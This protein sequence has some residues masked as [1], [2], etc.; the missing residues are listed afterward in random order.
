[1]KKRSLI[2]VVFVLL[3]LL[4]LSCE[5]ELPGSLNTNQSPRTRL[6]ISSEGI[7]NETLSKQH[8]YY[9]GEDPDGFISGYLIAVGKF[10]RS[11]TSVP[12]PD[13][14]T[15]VWTTRTDTVLSLPLLALRD[16]FTVLVR[17]VDNH[18]LP[19]AMPSGSLVKGFPN[20]YW[21]KDSNGFYS[22]GD[23][24]LTALAGAADPKGA[25]Q[26][27]P[28]VNTPPN[29]QFA[30]TPGDSPVT[31]EQP[32]TTFTAT[33]FS[34]V[35][36]DD[37]GNQTLKSYRL[38]LNDTTNPAN[39][40]ELPSSAFSK[41][42]KEADTVKVMLYVKRQDSDNAGP[43]VPAEIYI[44]VFGNLQYQGTINNLRLDAENVLYV[45]SKDLAGEYSKAARMPSTPSIKWFVKKP[46]SRMLVI[47]DYSFTQKSNG[48]VL[49]DWIMSYYRS[50]FSDPRVANGK[51]KDFDSFGFDRTKPN[52][53]LLYLN[54]AFVKTLQQYDVV[55]WFTDKLTNVQAAQIGLFYYT[56][57][58]NTERN[59]YGHVIFTT[60]F[61][62]NPTADQLRRYNDFAP[63]DGISPDA[64]YTASVLPWKDP[65]THLHTRMSPNIAGYPVLYTDSISTG[66][67][68]FTDETA[69][70]EV[71]Y[72]K[73]FKRTDSQYLYTLDSISGTPSPFKGS[74]ELG[75]IDNKKD[76]QSH[77]VMFGM[78][79]HLLNG[80]EHNLPF[81]FN[82]VIED[83]F[84][85]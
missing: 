57:M 26:R 64:D 68:V 69:E 17:A 73:L 29:V 62:T 81:F 14:L 48:V 44:G 75:I 83:E 12:S 2:A 39:W 85:L 23:V 45:E 58:L 43:T 79:L 49:R 32:E 38:A 4:A 61:V 15:Y 7:L 63:I 84:G 67:A 42:I 8:V 9:Y 46:K 1:M 30:M 60:Q 41:S 47:G 78:P 21:D 53:Y 66:G 56:T 74:M 71:Y 34:W 22:T 54:P 31:I 20:P 5:R 25:V 55:L 24:Y 27:I 19:A 72:K 65:V 40:F 3:A 33:T 10:A 50:I 35:G 77:F 16:S 82:K 52:N 76:N 80:W 37:D 70:H 36:S 13:T 28:I 51:F 18:F 59:T 6:W 11:V